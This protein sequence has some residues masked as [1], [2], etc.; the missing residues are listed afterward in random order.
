MKASSKLIRFLCATGVGLKLTLESERTLHLYDVVLVY[1]A[2]RNFLSHRI[3]HY[4][5]GH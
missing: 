3:S 1:N 4:M 5:D 2:K